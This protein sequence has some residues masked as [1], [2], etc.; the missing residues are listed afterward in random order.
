[1]AEGDVPSRLSAA[2]D[3]DHIKAGFGVGTSESVATVQRAVV[4]AEC[5]Q[6]PHVKGKQEAD[7]AIECA[8]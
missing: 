8:S 5:M 3:V 2:D 7:Q 4:V 6:E 1:M